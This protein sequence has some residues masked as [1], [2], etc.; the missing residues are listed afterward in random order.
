MADPGPDESID[1][2]DRAEPA[3]LAV[4]VVDWYRRVR[5][6]LPWRADPTPYKVL[7][8]ELMLQQT[9]V[10]TVVPYFERFVARWPDLA[11]FAAAPEAEVV[12]AWSGLGYYSR[13]RNLHRA[14]RAALAAGGLPSDPDALRALPGIGPY[15]AGA[16]A[17]IA[18]GVAAPAVDGNVERVIS[19]VDGRREDPKTPAGRRA[20]EAR[21][22]AMLAHAPPSDVSQG[23]ME[24]GATACSPRSPRCGACPWSPRC[25]ARARGWTDTLP[26]RRAKA[27]PRPIAAVAG[28]WRGPRG[29]LVGCRPEG[30]LGGLYEPISAE[31]PEGADAEA[32]LRRAFLDRVGVDVRVGERLG[33]V[34]HTFTHRRLTLTVYRVAGDGEPGLRSV[35]TDL[36][37]VDPHAP[38]GVA[39]STLARR[40][41]AL[42]TPAQPGLFVTGEPL[43]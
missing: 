34:V 14:A 10:D 29:V 28:L 23:L 19:R 20:I 37:W 40:T 33:D 5:R 2:T 1:D 4:S 7:L 39:L 36:A 13:A 31:L 3:W 8:S 32:T 43:D 18:F 12:Q 24:L 26:T 6:A 22:A 41:L 15:T 27:P 35:Y 11:A 30:L 25:V 42:A 16:I 38:A 21:V 17:S 9:R